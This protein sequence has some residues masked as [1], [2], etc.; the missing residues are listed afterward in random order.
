MLPWK[1]LVPAKWQAASWGLKEGGYLGTKT[2]SEVACDT[3]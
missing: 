1:M 2:A 3:N